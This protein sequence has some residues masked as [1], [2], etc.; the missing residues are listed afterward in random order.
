MTPEGKIKVKF[1]KKLTSLMRVYKF[2]PVQ[3]GMGAPGLDF[4]MCV[5]GYF[6]AVEAKA[7]ASKKPT[8][9]QELTMSTIR[10]AGGLCFVVFD[11]ASIDAC[12]EVIVRLGGTN[13]CG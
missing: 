10:E 13:V 4:Y 5:N 12:I 7:N 2:C 6:V 1:S 9:R 3:N 11:D 8:P